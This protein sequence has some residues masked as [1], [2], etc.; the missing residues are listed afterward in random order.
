VRHIYKY[1]LGARFDVYEVRLPEKAT[2]LSV[3]ISPRDGL[4][5]F[6]AEVEPQALTE[7]RRFLTVPT[8]GLAAGDSWDFLG[9][10]VEGAFV[11]Q[12]YVESL[13]ADRPALEDKHAAQLADVIRRTD[14]DTREQ[15]AQSRR[16]TAE[17]CAKLVES[18]VLI[19]NSDY[20]EGYNAGLRI[21]AGSIRVRFGG[22]NK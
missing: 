18:G 3:G 12:I 16:E 19:E 10:V 9:T 4:P 22:E 6:W 1:V 15:L 2:I 21:G 13:R 11:V 14:D 17:E 20:R 7:V 5:C 8:G